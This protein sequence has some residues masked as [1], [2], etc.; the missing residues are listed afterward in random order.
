MGK[1][2][3]LKYLKEAF[4]RNIILTNNIEESKQEIN[5]IKS[6]ESE[7]DLKTSL[8]DKDRNYIIQDSGY[9]GMFWEKIVEEAGKIAIEKKGEIEENVISLKRIEVIPNEE[10]KT[11]ILI[12]DISP[13]INILKGY[14]A[15]CPSCNRKKMV[16]SKAKKT[17]DSLFENPCYGSKG[18]QVE[19]NFE[20][21][22]DTGYLCTAYD[23]NDSSGVPQFTL[24]FFSNKIMPEKQKE[25]QQ[26]ETDIQTKNLIIYCKIN[27][28]PSP[29]KIIEWY[30]EVLSYEFEEKDIDI[31]YDLIRKFKDIPKNNKFFEEY[32]TPKIY[33]KTL[34][35]RINAV[36]LLSPY[37]I[38]LPNKMVE[39]GFLNI[40]EEGDPGQAKTT[41]KRELLKYCKDTQSKL[42]SVE[43]ATMRGLIGAA[44]K[45]PTTGQYMIK[46]GVI[47]LCHKCLIILDGIGKLTQED[48]TQLRGIQEEKHFQIQKAGSIKK[49]CAVRFIGLG[50]LI[51]PVDD[52]TTKHKASF[53]LSAVEGDKSNKFSGADRRRYDHIIVC[54]NEDTDADLIDN[55]IIK[56]NNQDNE[57]ELIK[58]WNNLR[59]FAWILRENEILWEKGIM[60]KAQI[61][62]SKLRKKYST[63][64]L[65]YSILSKG[66]FKKFIIQLPAVAILCG[67]INEKYNVVV[68]E[69]HIKWL[70]KLYEDE[71][72]DLGLDQ[73]NYQKE[74]YDVHAENILNKCDN[75]IIEILKWIAEY[76]NQKRVEEHQKISRMG[77]WRAFKEII[78]YA[79]DVK[80]IKDEI[81]EISTKQYNYSFTEGSGS[82]TIERRGDKEHLSFNKPDGELPPLNKGDGTLTDFGKILVKKAYKRDVTPVT[83]VTVT[84]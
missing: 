25:R 79:L 19:V 45:S 40:L 21:I 39:Y 46:I 71:L 16:S 14:V 35:K 49:E 78:H 22:I 81:E 12:N 59:E 41:E 69:K 84:D 66:G 80:E 72:M 60:E 43:N 38:K 1:K 2:I 54:G 53:D 7:E 27:T 82:V 5:K 83:L 58:Y 51:K 77:I 24:I 23:P 31:D 65:D 4:L 44:I 75:K 70:I 57:K 74:I 37:K 55:H 50:N 15:K 3:N 73:E 10:I 63:F 33:G 28:I 56:G 26:F 32:F 30:L 48:L 9:E 36:S 34:Q 11:R 61:V 8:D 47:P 17:C 13:G 42:V 76:G 6:I 64:S 20:P 68:K 62:I 67:E 29:K 18:G 52:Y